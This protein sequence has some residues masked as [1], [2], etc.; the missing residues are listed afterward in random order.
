MAAN[1][2]LDAFLAEAPSPEPAPAAKEPAAP[3]PEPKPEAKA[4]PAP[5]SKA[6]PEPKAKEPEPEDDDF[7]PARDGEVMVPRRAL[8]TERAK[9]NDYKAQAARYEGELAATKRALEEATQRAQAPQPQQQPMYQ[10]PA[11]DPASDP[12][13]YMR[14][15]EVEQAKKQIN[16]TLNVSEL[17]LR[18]E[19]GAEAVDAAITDFKAAA[20][21]DPRL[22]QQLY[23]QQDPYGWAYKQVERIRMLR[24]MG[25]DPAAFR[26]RVAAE[27]RA[28]WE[29]EALQ[30]RGNT[31]TVSPAAGLQP[32]LANARSMGTRSAAAWTDTSVEDVVAQIQNRKKRTG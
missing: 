2:Q 12:A 23:S 15:I 13:G 22:Y 19:V 26:A 27:E 24:D 16:H 30:P 14:H 6:A 9:R 31:V 28:K 1:D 18:K 10:A 20:D 17:L 3:A 4:T 21:Q 7:E 11:P 8:E 5:E 25:D 29:A 32:S